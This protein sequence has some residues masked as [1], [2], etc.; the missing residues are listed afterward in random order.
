MKVPKLPLALVVL[1]AVTVA[2]CGSSAGGQVLV[3]AAASLTDAFG[4]IEA[5]YEQAHPKAEV[6]L[7]LAGSSMLREQ[8]LEGAPADVYASANESNMA[9]LVAAGR[10]EGQPVRF[11]LNRMQIAVPAGNPAGVAGLGDFARKDLLV[12]ICTPDV[13]CGAFAEAIFANAGV[14]PSVDTY[15]PNVRALL[16][17]V[18]TGDLD[19][20]LVYATDVISAGGTVDGIELPEAVQV[21]ATYWI[22]VVADAPDPVEARRFVDFVT[23]DEGRRILAS[24]GFETP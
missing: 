12:G 16:T 22:A 13:P 9:Q 6:V 1:A 8:I 15:E 10:I 23:S 14:T 21:V 19:A 7:N 4:A 20:A 17:K 24:F 2:A 5:A 11:A 18:E 3:S